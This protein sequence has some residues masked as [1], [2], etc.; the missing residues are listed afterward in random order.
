M[1]PP[2]LTADTPVFDILHPVTISI[3]ILSRIELQLIIHY[4][5]Q[6]H[7]G[8][9]LHFKE[10]LH[11]K[12]RFNSYIG[13]F[14]ETYFIGISF[15]FFQQTCCSQIFFNLFANIEAV[16]T[17][18]HTSSF[19]DSSIIVEDINARQI[20]FLTQHI[21]VHIVSRCYLQ[22]SCTELNIY[23]VVFNNW[24]HTV[25]QRHNHLLTLQPLI[26]RVVRIDTHCSIT[27]N[28]FRTS[29]CNNCIT[30]FCVTFYLITQIKQL[31]VFFLINYFF[32]TQCSQGF[33]IPV[34]HTDPTI[35]QALIIKVDKYL[36]YTF[37]AFFIHCESSTIPVARCPQFTQLLQ[38]NTSVFFC[39][40]PCVLQELLTSQISLFNTL[41]CQFI[42]DLCFC[43]NRSMVS[44][45]YPTSIFPHHTGTTYQNILNGIVKHVSHVENSGHIWRWNNDGIRFTS[46]RFRTE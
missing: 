2:Q 34:Y 31:A 41:L 25:H 27:H 10:P 38:N 15:H 20:V 22:T 9:M 32:I 6:S 1:S 36:D 43:C 40:S 28:C 8:K 29:S 45:R 3:L 24:N 37:A 18:I 5:W 23:I 11:R 30:S 12:F 21:V 39:P 44:T 19:T 26:L 33:R 16:H 42:H 35:N 4:R 13:T 46:V 14:R 17:H 7:I